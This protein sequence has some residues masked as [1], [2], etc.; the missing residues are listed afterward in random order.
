MI[1]DRQIAMVQRL[2]KKYGQQCK[3]IITSQTPSDNHANQPWKG[4]AIGQMPYEVYIA[5]LRP[6]GGLTK[7]L[8]HLMT[9]TDIPTG[10]PR[11]IMG[12]VSFV[13]TLNDKVEQLTFSES[14]GQYT[15]GGTDGVVSIKAI[16][17]IAPN[18]QV[19]AYLLEFC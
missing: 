7:A 3:W 13:P 19:I 2:V 15:F 1:Y 11:G 18:G 17:P 8:Q 14:N 10:A 5:F 4:T 9:G 6:G 16:D 12:Q